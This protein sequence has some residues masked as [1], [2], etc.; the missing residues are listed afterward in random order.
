MG[1]PQLK[2]IMKIAKELRKNNPKLTHPQA[3]K[4]AWVQFKKK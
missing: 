4:E 1:N 2:E 3:V